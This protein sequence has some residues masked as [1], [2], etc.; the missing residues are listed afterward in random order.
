M[1]SPLT[2]I[3]DQHDNVVTGIQ[4]I[5]N[6]ELQ[7]PPCLKPSPPIGADSLMTPID[8]GQV[9]NHLVKSRRI[10]FNLVINPPEVEV[11]AGKERHH[12]GIPIRPQNCSHDLH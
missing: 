12:L 5:L 2:L 8:L 4:H 10:P 1:P 3:S 9:G 7:V 6:L 11:A